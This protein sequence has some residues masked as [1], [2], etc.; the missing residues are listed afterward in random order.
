MAFA[1]LRVK[2]KSESGKL[3][4]STFKFIFKSSCAGMTFIT[5]SRVNNAAGNEL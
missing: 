2:R 5:S 4:V 1:R 3:C